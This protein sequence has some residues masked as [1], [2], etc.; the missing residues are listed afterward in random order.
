[1]FGV[2]PL[3]AP[4][5]ARFGRWNFRLFGGGGI[6]VSV[7]RLCVRLSSGEMLRVLVDKSRR[8][9]GREQANKRDERERETIFIVC[10]T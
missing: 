10:N 7:L 4:L 6:V 3:P 1:V 8:D 2:E 9:G 5:F